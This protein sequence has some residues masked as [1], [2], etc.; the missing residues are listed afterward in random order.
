MDVKKEEGEP[1]LSSLGMGGDSA[2]RKEMLARHVF[3]LL[4]YLGLGSF[5][6]QHKND[7]SFMPSPSENKI[8]NWMCLYNCENML[9]IR[10]YMA[11]HSQ[12]I[13]TNTIYTFQHLR[14]FS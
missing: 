8:D 9:M 7:F 12:L 10:L 13:L 4:S 1:L 5:P 3:A 11:A 14:Q 2:R 6:Q